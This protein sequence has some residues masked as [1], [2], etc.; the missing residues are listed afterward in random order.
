MLR[1]VARLHFRTGHKA[2]QHVTCSTATLVGKCTFS[3]NIWMTHDLYQTKCNRFSWWLSTATYKELPFPAKVRIY[4][5]YLLV[6]LMNIFWMTRLYILSED[7]YCWNIWST[8][9]M[10]S[11]KVCRW[12][13][14]SKFELWHTLYRSYQMAHIIWAIWYHSISWLRIL[15]L[16]LFKETRRIQNVHHVRWRPGIHGPLDPETDRYQLVR[17][18]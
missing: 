8:V 11:W 2:V 7:S 10:P 15:D 1:P 18:F 4:E 17:D 12:V 3:N 16:N 13:M 9:R 5:S 14:D 6:K